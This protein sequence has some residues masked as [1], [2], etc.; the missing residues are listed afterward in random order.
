M[1]RSVKQN[2]DKLRK[3]ESI[4]SEKLKRAESKKTQEV[5]TPAGE[6]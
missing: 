3:S 5:L 6:A 2:S 4:K 1:P